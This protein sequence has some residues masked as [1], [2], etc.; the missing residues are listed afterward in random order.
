MNPR[1]H[2]LRW[3]LPV[4]L[5]VLLLG[6]SGCED[7]L[8]NAQRIEAPRVLGVRATTGNDQSSLERGQSARFEV[9][10]AGPEGPLAARVAYTLCPTARS[11]RGVPYCNQDALAAGSVDLAT[12]HIEVDVPDSLRQ[13]TSLALLGVACGEGEARQS[14]APL[15]WS[16]SGEEPPLRFSFDVWMSRA[17]F[18]NHNPD[19]SELRVN[20]GGVDVALDESQSAPSCEDGAMRMAAGETH[21]VEI[22]LGAASR[23]RVSGEADVDEALQ[24]SHF[25]TRG[26][27]ERQFSFVTE[28][29]RPE[30]KLA[31]TAPERS[32]P[33][34]QYLVVRDGRGGVSWASWSFCAD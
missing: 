25:S 22:T 28:R 30:V 15:N 34:K 33:V 17:E 6:S 12:D 23:E 14:G 9:L 4:S 27:F 18:T 8:K 20:V 1:R 31:W 3:S 11:V 2:P 7:P 19:L 29:N 21:D 5:L 10:F 26:L 16:C 24:L 13:D 32:D